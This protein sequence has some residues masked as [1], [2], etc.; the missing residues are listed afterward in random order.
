VLDIHGIMKM[1]PHRFPFLLVDRIID[2]VPNECVTG[3][4]NVT[5]NE[6]YF[7]GHWPKNPV[8]PGVLII[9]A[10]AQ[11]SSLLIFG[12]EGQPTGKQ[13]YFMGI[14]NAKFRKPAVPG[15]QIVLES[16]MV[17]VRRNACRVKAVAK[18]DGIICTQAEMMF[19]LLDVAG[20]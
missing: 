8:M 12:P 18:I 7:Q 11:V 14:D 9:E 2:Y 15:D 16:K 20:E 6:P 1:L 13:A 10:L 4:K 3:I 17:R 19:G 5:I